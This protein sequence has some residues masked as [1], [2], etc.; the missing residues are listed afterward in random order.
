MTIT[1]SADQEKFVQN[2]VASGSYSSPEQVVTTALL[3]LKNQEE[4]R[5]EIQIGIDQLDGGAWITGEE[6]FAHPGEKARKLG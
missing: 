2:L 1:L 6:T 3:L 4:L 5:H